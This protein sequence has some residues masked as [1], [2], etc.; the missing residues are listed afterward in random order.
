MFSEV[1][2]EEAVRSGT[3]ASIQAEVAFALPKPADFA[4]DEA[5]QKAYA[6]FLRAITKTKSYKQYVQEKI[7]KSERASSLIGNM[8]TSSIFLALISTFEADLKDGIDLTGV[9]FGF[10]GYGSGSKSK[11]FEGEVQAGWKQVVER[12]KLM[13]RL[14]ARHAIDYLT[15]EALHRKQ[16]KESVGEVYGEFYLDA[17]N[18][19]P[20]NY[21]G[22]R[23]YRWKYEHKRALVPNV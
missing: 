18:Q 16:L 14:E 4:S 22:A 1:F 8:Y 2:F 19:E 20:G 13:D 12:W 15:Y 11:V 21:T 7:E 5:Y 9:R 17:V 23:T 6:E 3:W 10:F